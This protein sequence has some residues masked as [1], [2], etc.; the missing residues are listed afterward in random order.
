MFD[1]FS[2][3]S[4]Y[5][6]VY[7]GNHGSGIFL[8]AHNGHILNRPVPLKIDDLNLTTDLHTVLTFYLDVEIHM[9]QIP[10]DYISTGINSNNDKYNP[11]DTQ[12]CCKM[13]GAY[14]DEPYIYNDLQETVCCGC[15][16]WN[17]E[18][19]V[20]FTKPVINFNMYEWIPIKHN[21]LENRN[22]R[23][24]LYMR[25]LY[26]SRRDENEKIVLRLMKSEQP[27]CDA[28]FQTMNHYKFPQ[29]VVDDVFKQLEHTS[30]LKYNNSGNG[31]SSGSGG[32]SGKKRPKQELNSI[33]L[34]Q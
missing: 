3:S 25:R 13:C 2:L 8:R 31:G 22:P 30:G 15:N 10:G 12:M 17:F 9:I 1:K 6:V 29:I 33:I 14:K 20:T 11:K 5:H 34:T 26:V 19:E 21:I 27:V 16:G 7:S 32:N 24:D 18:R 4:V 23:S 28:I